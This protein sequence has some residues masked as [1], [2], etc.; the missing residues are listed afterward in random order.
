MSNQKNFNRGFTI[1]E[2]IVSL[3]IIGLLLAVAIN[4]LATSKQ[5]SRDAK[6]VDEIK[7]IQNALQL[8]HNDNQSYPA[9]LSG[10]LLVP[11]YIKVIPKDPGTG[12]DYLYAA[13][14]LGSSCNNY[15]LGARLE[16][17]PVNTGTLETDFDSLA[18]ENICPG[19]SPDFDGADPVY[20]AHP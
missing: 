9:T 19:S 6:R 16:I 13:L 8:Y 3:A 12:N 5:K 10:D 20:D 1:L 7:Q 14:L 15:H 2:L 11:V 18:S 4:G 17:T